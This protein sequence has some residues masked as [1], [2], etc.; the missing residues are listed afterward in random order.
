[1]AEFNPKEFIE[2]LISKGM[3]PDDPAFV[4]ALE[5]ANATRP[6][7][8]LQVRGQEG[9]TTESSK[10]KIKA[11]SAREILSDQRKQAKAQVD[12]LV[13]QARSRIQSGM[14]RPEDDIIRGA[15]QALQN[16]D[17]NLAPD[18]PG[19]AVSISNEAHAM[20]A[21]RQADVAEQLRGLARSTGAPLGADKINGWVKESFDNPNIVDDLKSEFERLGAEE[22]T[23]QA[24]DTRRKA[25]SRL[26]SKHGV[27]RVMGADIQAATTLEELSEIARND[28]PRRIK[29]AKI[30]RGLKTGGIAGLAGLVALPAL[31]ALFGSEGRESN[32][33]SPQQKFQLMMAMAENQGGGS[34]GG[35]GQ[36]ETGRTLNN[37]QKLLTITKTLQEA[38]GMMG[39]P[40]ANAGLV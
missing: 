37:I 19:A 9:R 36:L 33:L 21:K 38:Q 4:A 3:K 6:L 26:A 27:G 28:I 39:Q 35:A 34:D 30:G 23:R 22:K 29:G 40:S 7:Q 2:Y 25:V 18:A 5:F 1:M 8:T 17:P 10:A 14:I 16:I 11:D 20:V 15:V 32:E 31:Q 12:A 24:V 13:S